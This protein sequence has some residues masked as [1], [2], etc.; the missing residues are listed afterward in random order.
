MS[1]DSRISN[2]HLIH[3]ITGYSNEDQI[4]KVIEKALEDAK[5]K[6]SFFINVL[7]PKGK[8]V[9]YSYIWVTSE[10]AFNFLIG[11]QDKGSNCV[12]RLVTIPNP[13]HKEEDDGW[14]L[15]PINKK[16]ELGDY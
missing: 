13:D 9:K 16:M 15:V 5:I 7:A 1:F 2:G 14:H 10:E 12:K 4:S 3:A 11:F 8:Y 6:S